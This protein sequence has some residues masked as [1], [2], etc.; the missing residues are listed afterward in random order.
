MLTRRDDDDNGVWRAYVSKG[1]EPNGKRTRSTHTFY[2]NAAKTI[3]AQEHD[4]RK[5]VTQWESDILRGRVTTA[6]KI[7]LRQLSAEWMEDYKRGNPAPI[8]VKRNADMLSSRV[9]HQ[10]G[11]SRCGNTPGSLCQA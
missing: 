4:I 9:I 2:V 7:T 10:L 8:S 1:F 5:Q 6:G 3:N 11:N